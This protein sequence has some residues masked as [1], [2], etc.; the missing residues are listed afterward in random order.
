[1]LVGRWLIQARSNAQRRWHPTTLPPFLLCLCQ[2]LHPRRLLPHR[3]LHLQ[4][5][6]ML[7]RRLRRPH[8]PQQQ[9]R[10]CLGPRTKL[11]RQRR[12]MHLQTLFPRRLYPQQ[13]LFHLVLLLCQ[14]H[15]QQR[16]QQQQR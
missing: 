15:H 5:Q 16:L 8:R 7:L 6:P 13:L 9:R 4:P 11:P 12:R 14:C 10:R 2:R 3:R 1:V